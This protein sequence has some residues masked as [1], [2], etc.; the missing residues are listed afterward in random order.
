M[1]IGDATSQAGREPTHPHRIKEL[2]QLHKVLWLFPGP[3]AS[4]AV[5]NSWALSHHAP[6]DVGGTAPSVHCQALV[7]L[8]QQSDAPDMARDIPP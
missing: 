3:R 7:A 6:R 4:S 1:K 8:G 2:S 5:L